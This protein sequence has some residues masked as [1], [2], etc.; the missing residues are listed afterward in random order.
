VTHDDGWKV[1]DEASGQ[2]AARG[3][4]GPPSHPQ[5]PGVTW[6]GDGEGG[7][8]IYHGGRE[9]QI[10]HRNLIARLGLK[11][12]RSTKEPKGS[13]IAVHGSG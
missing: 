3:G 8:F 11:D 9:R 5:A 6:R 1:K 12:V 4:A 13:L 10:K 7:G 2:W